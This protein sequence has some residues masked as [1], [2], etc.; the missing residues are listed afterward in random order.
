MLHYVTTE[1]QEFPSLDRNTRDHEH[2]QWLD[3]ASGTPHCTRRDVIA[4][5]FASTVRHSA[6]FSNAQTMFGGGGG[7]MD[8]MMAAMFG[9]GMDP[10]MMAAMMGGGGR[11]RRRRGKDVGHAL[12]VTLEDLYNGTTVNLPRDKV[13]LCDTCKG[14]GTSKPGARPTCTACRGQGAKLVMR[15]MGP[16]IQR[17]Q[18]PC[19]VCN[20]SG[21]ITK[22]GDKCRTCQG[23]RTKTIS[24]PLAVKILRGMEHEQHIPFAGE[25]DQDPDVEAP[26]DIVAVLQQLKHE[27]FVRDG[28]DLILKKKLS[29]A[30]ALCG[31]QFTVQHLDERV[32]LVSNNP[33]QIVKPGDRKCVTGQGMPIYSAR[34]GPG[35]PLRF[36][37]LIIEFEIEFPERVET[38]ALTLLKQALPAAAVDTESSAAADAEECYLHPRPLDEVRKEMQSQA[39]DDDDDGPQGGGGGVRCAQQ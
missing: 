26:G 37:D 36:G 35:A 5:N 10:S 6:T 25:G 4:E 21:A 27:R 34:T 18:V 24:S 33:G 31:F 30:E 19:D 17:M 9:G 32:L 2:E 15:Q 38:E 11:G 29:L 16:M 39:D 20:G 1:R 28:N 7:D 12:P 3:A 8:D 23:E 13:V 22:P 14:S